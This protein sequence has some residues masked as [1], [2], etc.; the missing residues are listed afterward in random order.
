MGNGAVKIA[1]PHAHEKSLLA[2]AETGDYETVERL[3]TQRM[4]VY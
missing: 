3:L 4:R 2:A 1:N